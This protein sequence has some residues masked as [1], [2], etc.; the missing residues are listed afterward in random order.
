MMVGPF[1]VWAVATFVAAALQIWRTALQQQLTAV[2]ASRAVRLSPNGGGFVRYAFGGPW[3]VLAVF[4][5]VLVGVTIPAITARFVVI[6]TVGGA[7]QILATN[8]LI[9]AFQL[10]DFAI[11]TAY[12]KTEA[13]QAA[14]L[15]IPFLGESMS[16]PAWVGIGVSLVGVIVLAAKGDVNMLRSMFRGGPSDP[17]M[18]AGFGAGTGFAIAALCIRAAAR[19][20]GDSQPIVR[21]LV[22][23]AVMNTIQMTVNGAWLLIAD[24]AQLV[25]IRAVWKQAA[26]VGA[27]SALGSAGWAIGMT[28]QS[29]GLVRAFG[30]ID[31][32]FAFL[33]AR[34]VLKEE[35]KR[36]EYIGSALVVVGVALVLLA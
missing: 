24:R 19:E 27:L 1:P 22:T 21:A 20:L 29:A 34:F 11:G 36:T 8:A 15:S 14:L 28:L 9:R 4:V 35:R 25:A 26:T 16:W 31:L 7:A 18:L 17:A 12:S 13:M 33:V 30:Q 2:S 10:R 6:I 23:L 3:A 32:V 5:M